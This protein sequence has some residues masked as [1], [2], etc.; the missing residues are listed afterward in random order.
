[1]HDTRSP[2]LSHRKLRALVARL[3]PGPLLRAAATT[4][5]G[6]GLA[7]ATVAPHS[8]RADSPPPTATATEANTATPQVAPRDYD[9]LAAVRVL[10]RDLL[11]SATTR[12]EQLEMGYGVAASDRLALAGEPPVRLLLRA[13]GPNARHPEATSL[14]T[15]ASLQVELDHSLS[16]ALKQIQTDLAPYLD[17]HGRRSGGLYLPFGLEDCARQP[18]VQNY[19]AL[20]TERGA[21]TIKTW[22]QRSGRYRAMIETILAEEGVPRDLLYLAMIESGY[23]PTVK[24]PANAGGMWQFIPG[25]AADMGLRI[26]EYVDERFDPV[27]AT[28][29]A[30]RYLKKQHDRFGS[31]PLAMAAYNG[32]AGTVSKGIQSFNANDYFKLVEYGA[33]YDETRRYVPRILA[34]ALI[35]ENPHAFGF[36]GLTLDEPWR[37]D[38]VE[39]PGDVRLSLLADAAGTDLETLESLNPELLRKQ[40]P[41][42]APYV[43]RIPYGTLSTFVTNYDDLARKY[44]PTHT[45]HTVRFGESIAMIARQYG[46][47][48]RVLREVNGLGRRDRAPYGSQLIVPDKA[49]QG[50]SSDKNEARAEPEVVLVPN[51]DE[52]FEFKDRTRFFYRVNDGDTLE[53]IA[54]HFGLRRVE[55]ALWN[56]LDAVARLNDGLVLQLFLDDDHPAIASSVLVPDGDVRAIVIGSEEYHAWRGTKD[57]G[58]NNK[59]RATGYKVKRGDTVSKIAKA[60]GVSSEDIIRWNNLGA[61]AIIKPGMRLVIHK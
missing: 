24:S 48:E 19:L 38:E 10:E 26:D 32:G 15:D 49:S 57:G 22:I 44:G 13:T 18:E 16:A 34:A 7:T 6:L 59:K 52:S 8:A 23:R 58:S 27:K 5:A 53:E 41:P 25:T 36:A 30:A 29:A 31:W 46:V 56:D 54:A 51:L 9:E 55:I 21:T 42:G 20:F 45:A 17:A 14:R 43:L 11:P 1:M 3:V 4:V 60:H 37:Y 61:K 28:R 33:M 47:P 40:T 2:R 39:V 12:V 35:A 50:A